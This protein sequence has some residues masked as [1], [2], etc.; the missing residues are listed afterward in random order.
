MKLP[1]IVNP[2]FRII[3]HRGAS[4]Y[5]P[6]NTP[7][8]FQLAVDMGIKEIEL[9]VQLSLDKEVVICH[10]LSL[11][12][13]GYSGVIEA[14]N[15]PDLARLDM[16]SWFSPFLYSNERMMRLRDLFRQYGARFI[17]HIEIKGKS[18]ELPHQVC[19]LVDQFNLKEKVVITSF[20]FEALKRIRRI[21]PG[22]RLGW[23]VQ[24]LDQS[25]LNRSKELE[26]LQLC[27]KAD[28][29]NEQDVRLAHAVVP[30]IRVWG[31]EGQREEVLSLIQKIIDTGCDG[32]TLNWPDWISY[33]V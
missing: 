33:P 29:I 5:A 21:D 18:E 8:A 16:G 12:R 15:W 3:A 9:D 31:I 20:S 2:P 26:L 1:F 27:P 17:H 28:S 10:D 11:E 13:Y 22:L 4:A 30:E 19:R 7:A 25:I 24:N 14:M 32:A 6:E 23:L